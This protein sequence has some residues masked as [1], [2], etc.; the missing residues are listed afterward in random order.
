MANGPKQHPRAAD[1]WRLACIT[2]WLP[3][4]S[5]TFILDELQALRRLHPGLVVYTLYGPWRR[6]ALSP[7]LSAAGLEV[8]RLGLRAAGRIAWDCARGL[9]AGGPAVRRFVRAAACRRWSDL[10]TAGENLWAVACGFRIARWARQQRVT[11]L[12]AC[13]ANGPATAAWVAARLAGLPFSFSAWAGDIFPPDGALAEKLRAAACAR[14]A[15]RTFAPHLRAH[16]G[17]AADRVQVV[18]NGQDPARFIPGTPALAPPVRLLALGRLVAKKGFDLALHAAAR[19]RQEGVACRLVVAGDG[20]RG[21][22]LRKLAARLGLAGDV[23]FTGFVPRHRTRELFG[24]CDVFL[25][26]SRV[27]A[28]GDRDGIPNVIMEALLHGVPVIASAVGGIPEIVKDGETGRLIPPG[29]APA[30][31]DAVRAMVRDPAAARA[32]AARGRALVL[33]EHDLETTSRAL[34]RLLREGPA[35]AADPF[36]GDSRRGLP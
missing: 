20:P 31:A 24:N 9:W 30:L 10:E 17:P 4:P 22:A 14:S 27:D 21:R 32:M 36:L 19:L 13:W 16:A 33:R 25:A 7:G 11:H 1:D 2:H 5:E 12:H 18:L 3:K 29:D 34:L 15:C 28:H 35:A 8:R 23:V 6:G 26:P